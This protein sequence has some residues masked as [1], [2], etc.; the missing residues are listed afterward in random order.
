M[1]GVRGGSTGREW[2]YIRGLPVP[3][4]WKFSARRDLLISAGYNL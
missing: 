3:D 1:R 4:R 2:E